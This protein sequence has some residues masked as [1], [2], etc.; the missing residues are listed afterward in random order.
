MQQKLPHNIY[1]SN[2][3]FVF[4]DAVFSCSLCDQPTFG[5][6]AAKLLGLCGNSDRHPLSIAVT[7]AKRHTLHRTRN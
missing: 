2:L 4:N 6:V 3:R 1:D 5:D 7:L